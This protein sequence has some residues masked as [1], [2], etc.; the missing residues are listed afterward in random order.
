MMGNSVEMQLMLDSAMKATP[1]AF[2]DFDRT[3]N[4]QAQL[5][6]MIFL[7]DSML[8]QNF[9][10]GIVFE[11]CNRGYLEL[12]MVEYYKQFTSMEQ[13]WLGFYMKE[14]H[15]KVWTGSEWN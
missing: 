1:E 9:L 13:L 6:E 3:K 2:K 11:V 12:G 10:Y 8:E 5:Q 15:G 4:V 7:K 14:K